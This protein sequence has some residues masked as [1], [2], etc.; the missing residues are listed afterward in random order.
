VYRVLEATVAYATLICTF[1]YYYDYYYRQTERQ[2]SVP[3]RGANDF[4]I[5]VNAFID[6]LFFKCNESILHHLRL[7][8]RIHVPLYNK[9]YVTGRQVQA[10]RKASKHIHL[11]PHT[12][13]HTHSHYTFCYHKPRANSGLSAASFATLYVT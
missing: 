3:H 7:T 11:A 13:V 5:G 8:L 1:Y 4:D 2:R 12:H 10:G 9:V 6:K